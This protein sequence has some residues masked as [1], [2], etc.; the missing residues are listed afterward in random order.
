M[1][2]KHFTAIAEI[3]GKRLREKITAPIAQYEAIES[4][5]NDLAEY[6][7]TQNSSFD[8]NRF[9]EAVYTTK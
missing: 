5:A 4:L 3:V 9:L 8:K 2:K 1:T 7:K 6:F